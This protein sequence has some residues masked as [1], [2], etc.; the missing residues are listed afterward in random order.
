MERYTVHPRTA[1]TCDSLG[2]CPKARLSV[3]VPCYNEQELIV[4]SD[5]R[6][7]SVLEGLPV[8]LELIYVDDGR[9]DSTTA[10]LRELQAGDV[11]IRVIRLSRNFGHQIAITAGLE[12]SSEDAVVI[13]D[14][15]GRKNHGSPGTGEGLGEYGNCRSVLGRRS[16]DLHGNHR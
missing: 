7:V 13:I 3:I 8:D 10:L 16:A 2:D 12:S 5:R 6:L 11:R 1:S 9:T 4:E 15:S 14:R